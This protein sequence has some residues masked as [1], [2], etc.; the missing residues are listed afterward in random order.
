MTCSAPIFLHHSTDSARV[1]EATTVKLLFLFRY[2]RANCNAQEL[3]AQPPGTA[4]NTALLS[5]VKRGSL[6]PPPK[7]S[8]SICMCLIM[9]PHAL[10]AANGIEAASAKDRALGLSEVTR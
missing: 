9:P 10:N 3:A 6:T 5:E 1:A 7:R 4:K 8:M 2:L